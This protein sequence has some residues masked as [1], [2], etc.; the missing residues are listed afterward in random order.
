MA[1]D[2]ETTPQEAGGDTADFSFVADDAFLIRYLEHHETPCPRCGYNLHALRST[3]CPECGESL[4]VTVGLTHPHLRGWVAMA[5]PTTASAGIGLLFLLMFALHGGPRGR[6]FFL[7]YLGLGYYWAAI[8]LAALMIVRR[9][10]FLRWPAG[11]QNT[12]A[13]AA[14][15]AL[16]AA[17]ALIFS[18]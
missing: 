9:R 10:T 3:R 13:V 11:V 16:F 5:V 1:G 8:P 7:L 15:V 2:H 14:W 12:V 17:M 4:R 18:G 6:G